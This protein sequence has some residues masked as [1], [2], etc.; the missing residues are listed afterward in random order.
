MDPVLLF[1]C[2]FC[3]LVWIELDVSFT[4]PGDPYLTDF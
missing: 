4:E 2:V 1:S 3:L